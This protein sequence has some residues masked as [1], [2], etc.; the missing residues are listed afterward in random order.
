MTKAFF[1]ELPIGK[2]IIILQGGVST[3]PYSMRRKYSFGHGNPVCTPTDICSMAEVIF[4]LA[5]LKRRG[6]T[7]PTLTA[8]LHRNSPVFKLKY[9]IGLPVPHSNAP[10]SEPKTHR[11]QPCTVPQRSHRP[12]FRP[13]GA[14]IPAPA[15]WRLSVS[16]RIA[17]RR[18]ED[19]ISK[20]IP[21]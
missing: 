10:D 3:I 1:P 16:V 18:K 7:R 8:I 5:I 14:P 20:L 9:E 15:N 4:A 17:V 13:G 12:V 2:G 11:P 21:M 6:A 19:H